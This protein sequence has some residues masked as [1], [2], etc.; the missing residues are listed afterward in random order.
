MHLQSVFEK[1]NKGN[2]PVSEKLARY[3]L[4]LPSGMALKESRIQ[5]VVEAIKKI[6]H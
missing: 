4:Y 1:Y 2:F 6:L 3:G 5:E